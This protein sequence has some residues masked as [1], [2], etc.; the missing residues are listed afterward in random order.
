MKFH[1]Y[2]HSI[3][4]DWNHGNAH[5]LRGIVR[6]LLKS[7]HQVVIYEARN[8]WSKENLAR[9]GYTYFYQ[10]QQYYPTFHVEEY[11]SLQEATGNI[12]EAD[13]VIVH[14]W[15]QQELVERI[16][17]LRLKNSF[18]LFFHDTHHRAISA[19]QEL[20]RYQLKNYDGVLAF[21]EVLKRVYLNKGWHEKVYTWHEA[22]DTDLFKPKPSITKKYDLVWVGNWG[23][24]E[25]A[26]EIVE[27][28]LKPVKELRLQAKIYG[29]RYPK[30]ALEQLEAHGVE[31]GGYLPNN[32]VPVVFNE[33]KLTVHVPRRPYM[34]ILPG[35]P[36]IRPFEA[37]A[38]GLPL[39]S[40]RW[41]DEENLFSELSIRY[42]DSGEET[43]SAM[44]EL[45]EDRATR[46]EQVEAGIVD[47]KEKHNCGS[48]VEQLLSIINAIR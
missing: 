9:E 28:L 1:L 27:Y 30:H 37:L 16:G 48:R 20:E 6:E 42:V 10:L 2:Y 29:V 46:T 41:R 39:I 5:F 43:A 15:N 12:Q 11:S 38:C 19:P 47:I 34:E 17:E 3:L 8:A 31:Y 44:V 35:I 40:R 23:D 21:G 45:L 22:A 14:E 36:T 26:E 4:S 7:K 32:L 18:S 25:R 33:A 24:D 13:V